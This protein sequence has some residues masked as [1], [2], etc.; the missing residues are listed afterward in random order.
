MNRKGRDQRIF[1]ELIGILKEKKTKGK[2]PGQRI[3]EIGTFFLGTPY[4]SG[5]LE[6]Q[7]PEH[8]IVNLRAYDCVT[9]VETVIAFACLVKSGEKSFE[10]FRSVL[11]KIRYRGGRLHGFGSRLH[12]FSDWIYDN[13]KKG[14]VRD[15]TAEIGGRP[16]KKVV[17]VMTANPDF[18][19][20]LKNATNLRELKSAERAINK[21][22]LCFIPK[23][24]LRR[25]EPLIQDG[26][27]I[28]VTTAMRG[29]D[30]Q[31]TGLAVRVRN[32][33]HLLHASRLAGKVVFSRKTL[34][35]YLTQSKMRT[36]IMVARMS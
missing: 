26:D 15:V 17:G 8:L 2:A 21:R 5:T 16:L 34:Y 13:E 1:K 25:L 27:L 32:R 11:R 6:T 3:L 35:R 10:A 7:K 30:V 33:I 19:P 28:A 14:V 22:S 4:A 18:Y 29:L 20:S 23:K 12:Y 24:I 36:G 31:H 9:F